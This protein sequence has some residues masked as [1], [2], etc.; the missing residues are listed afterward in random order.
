MEH[1]SI[2]DYKNFTNK[3]YVEMGKN[4]YNHNIKV[5]KKFIKILK[6]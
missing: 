5:Y 3:E 2:D 1:W 4:I 6:N